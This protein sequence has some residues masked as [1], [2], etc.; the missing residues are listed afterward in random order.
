MKTL[1]A[2]AATAAVLLA[3]PAAADPTPGVPYFICPSTGQ[4]RMYAPP[5]CPL[6][7]QGGAQR[8]PT[9]RDDR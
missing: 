5:P 9:E 6:G 4:T 3:P 7:P 8:V 1:L 2:V